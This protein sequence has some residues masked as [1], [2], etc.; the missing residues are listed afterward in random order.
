MTLKRGELT[1]RAMLPGAKEVVRDKKCH[2]T[3]FRILESSH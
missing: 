3:D 2:C 1:N